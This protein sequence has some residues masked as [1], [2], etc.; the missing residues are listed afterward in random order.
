[1]KCKILLRLHDYFRMLS[2]N[3][4]EYARLRISITIAHIQY[5]IYIIIIKL[6]YIIKISYIP[7]INYKNK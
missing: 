3:I 6:L 7:E 1:M 2:I 4:T 5:P